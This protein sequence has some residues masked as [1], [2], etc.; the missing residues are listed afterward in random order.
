MWKKMSNTATQRTFKSNMRSGREI[1]IIQQNRTP[2]N[3]FIGNN[4]PF[5]LITVNAIGL[6]SSLK[7]YRLAQWIKKN[8]YKLLSEKHN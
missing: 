7:R 6:S 8:Y 1:P 3:I 5:S 2:P 4:K